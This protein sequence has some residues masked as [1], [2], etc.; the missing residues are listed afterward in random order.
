MRL[1]VESGPDEGTSLEVAGDQVV[2][3]RD[4][5]CQLV[6]HDDKVSRRHA[7]IDLL[8]DG[9]FVLVDF[10]SSNGTLVNGT[11]VDGPY[12]L[13]GNERLRLGDTVIAVHLPGG[14]TV[15]ASRGVM[16]R[17]ESGDQH[18][19]QVEVTGTEFVIGRSEGCDLVLPDPTVSARH[20]ELSVDATGSVTLL[21][22]GSRNGTF[23]NG[24][25][26]YERVPLEGGER[27]RMGDTVVSLVT[28]RAPGVTVVAEVG[29]WLTVES[30][31][32]RGTTVKVTGDEFVIGR[33]PSCDLVLPD[34][35]VSHQ[36]ASLEVTG[37]GKAILT[38]LGSRNGTFVDGQ[39][40]YGVEELRGGERLKIGD[41]ELVFGEM[42]VRGAPVRRAG[43][44][45]GRRHGGRR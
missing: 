35:S 45:H 10:G 16:L 23:V 3:G 36:H 9:R 34:A 12:E 42:P 40:V 22:L 33:D 29:A 1:T 43:A 6:L 17:I 20:A 4:E 44:R 14:R 32:A 27:V 25:Q 37:P 5:E 31:P 8:P 13:Q 28:A 30:G 41:T 26:V 15:V 38:D 11:R 2:I 19:R 24:R 7:S 21:D 39:Q 18:G